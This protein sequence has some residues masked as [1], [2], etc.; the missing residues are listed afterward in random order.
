M[1]RAVLLPTH[2]FAPSIRTAQLVRQNYPHVPIFARSRH[3][4]HTHRLMDV[5]VQAIRS[6]TLL[7]SLDVTRARMRG[8]GSTERD[9]RFAVDTFKEQDRRHLYEDY[10]HYTDIEK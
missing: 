1:A 7:S 2:N 8:L 4:Q 9:V 6:E 5:G 10:K 3:R